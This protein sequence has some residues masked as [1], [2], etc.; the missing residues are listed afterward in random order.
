MDQRRHIKGRA[1]FIQLDELSCMWHILIVHIDLIA[2][3]P[4]SPHPSEYLALTSWT[5]TKGE[6]NPKKTNAAIP[7]LLGEEEGEGDG[8]R[9]GVGVGTLHHLRDGGVELQ[10]WGH[11]TVLAH[12]DTHNHREAH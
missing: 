9:G 2:A 12:T 3:S 11:G 1:D 6:G 5:S 10:P 8:V 7:S 4:L